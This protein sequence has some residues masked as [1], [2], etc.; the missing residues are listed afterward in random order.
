M[1]TGDGFSEEKLPS[2]D[3]IP[4]TQGAT[5][6]ASQTESA[7]AHSFTHHPGDITPYKTT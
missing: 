1:R 2:E 5:R 4:L 6:E 3:L 7:A